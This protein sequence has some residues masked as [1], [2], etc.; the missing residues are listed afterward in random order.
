M[1]EVEKLLKL[2][3]KIDQA[4]V[5]QNRIEGELKAY[6]ARLINDFDCQTIDEAKLEIEQ[7][8]REAE[9]LDLKIKTSLNQNQLGKDRGRI[10]RDG[11]SIILIC[12]YLKSK[13]E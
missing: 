3:E 1:T 12:H 11:R 8:E 7:L 9:E 13:Q 2:K 6:Q 4:S 5:K 10:E